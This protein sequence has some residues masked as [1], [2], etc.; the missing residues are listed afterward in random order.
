[1]DSLAIGIDLGT[2]NSCAAYAEGKSHV[3]IIKSQH[4]PT[5]QGLVFP[6]FLRFDALGDVE[7][8]GEDARLQ[9]AIAPDSVV[10]GVK[11]LIG[12]SFYEV[13]RDLHR[14]AYQ[15]ERGPDGRVVISM[16]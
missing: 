3:H 14:F 4:G 2:Y 16:T 6:S 1:M 12:R 8:Y 9:M 13:E 10:W 7:A 11:R 15:I 5:P